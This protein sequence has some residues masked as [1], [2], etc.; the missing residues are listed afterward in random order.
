MA[1]TRDSRSSRSLFQAPSNFIAIWLSAILLT[2]MVAHV[3]ISAPTTDVSS[4]PSGNTQDLIGQVF[5]GLEILIGLGNHLINGTI[6]DIEDF[7]NVS[8]VKKNT[9]M[10][11]DIV[12]TGQ[13][14]I[15]ITTCTFDRSM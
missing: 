3:V 1:F 8:I 13:S 12:C 14:L 4:E 5:N 10:A 11:I 7:Q 9:E 15:V 2:V 6:L